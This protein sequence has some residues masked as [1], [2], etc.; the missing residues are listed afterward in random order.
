[1][2][3]DLKVVLYALGTQYLGCDFYMAK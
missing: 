1:M 3:Q 2:Y